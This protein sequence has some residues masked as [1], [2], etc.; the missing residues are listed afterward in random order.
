V[1]STI[2]VTVYF[3]KVCTCYQ[4]EALTGYQIFKGA[5]VSDYNANL[6][7]STS[8]EMIKITIHS[9]RAIS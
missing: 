1:E 3:H 7:A 4:A 2:R 9:T 8:N 5:G 6:L